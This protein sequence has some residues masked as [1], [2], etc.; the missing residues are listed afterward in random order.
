M[1]P[2]PR[3][4][5][6]ISLLLLGLAACGAEST[7]VRAPDAP[8]AASRPPATEDPGPPSPSA[9][10]AAT[11]APAA[12]L[13]PSI[14]VD[15]IAGADAARTRALFAPIRSSLQECGVGDRGAFVVQ[16]ER[17][18]DATKMHIEPSASLD[19][20]ARR[21]ALEILSTVDTD[22]VLQRASPADRASGFSAQ[23]RIEW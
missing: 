9:K 6:S 4:L 10:P 8:P 5:G 3:S 16:F 1:S 19:P 7:V 21:C 14:M 22:G 15:Q 18:Q 12:R 20:K 17:K 23:I 2:S 13:P 11:A